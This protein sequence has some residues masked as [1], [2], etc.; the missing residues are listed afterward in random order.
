MFNEIMQLMYQVQQ[1]YPM[2]RFAQIVA[3]AAKLGGWE[4]DDVFYCDDKT[5]A[6][7]LRILLRENESSSHNYVFRVVK[8][9]EENYGSS[10]T[11]L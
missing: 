9:E 7:G 4:G 6:K 8:V 11:G 3:N 2:L 10:N 5:M 1:A